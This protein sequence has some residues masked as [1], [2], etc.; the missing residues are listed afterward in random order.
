MHR[1]LEEAGVLPVRMRA[2]ELP[3]AQFLIV[4]L[5][6]LVQRL[7]AG[8]PLDDALSAVLSSAER[9][10][11]ADWTGIVLPDP[12]R[13]GGQ[14]AF[15]SPKTDGPPAEF[16]DPRLPAWIADDV[17]RLGAAVAIADTLDDPRTRENPPAKRRAIV[18][19][20]MCFESRTLGVLLASWPQPRT[21]PAA[22]LRLL[23]ILATHGAIALENAR[24]H[25]REVEARRDTETA[26]AQLQRFLDSVAHD[27]EG[28]LTLIVAYGELLRLSTRRDALQVAQQALP[29]MER[30][31]RRIQRLVNDLLAV[32]RIGAR[33]FRVSPSVM[34]LV[35]L[36]QDV[37]RQQQTLTAEHRLR[38]LAPPR[39]V[40]E[41]DR[42]R[43]GELFGNLIANAI[44]YSLDGGDIEAAVDEVGDGVIV[45]ISDHGMGI[46][47]EHLPLLF[48]PF[49]RLDPEPT[50]TGAGLG[51]YLAK[52]IVELHGG[53]IWVKSEPGHGSTFAVA[54]PR[55]SP[56]AGL[57]N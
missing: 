16:E 15:T 30:A 3:S 44:R 50:T 53:R 5:H 12:H 13:P 8:L 42:D 23:Q 22:D 4:E 21:L 7:T 31:A 47:P 37:L 2:D 55:R 35:V 49:T 18:A 27:L 56:T 1:N 14:R 45:K 32:A 19:V 9:V 33:T 11:G 10:V 26:H 17:L 57:S 28:P 48:Q 6:A 39:V 43:L 20:P 25:A 52:T 41:W 34:D 40:G 38:L 46:P 29:G 24:L 51:L 54:L 36:L